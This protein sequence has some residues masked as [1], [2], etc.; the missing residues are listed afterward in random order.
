MCTEPA[1]PSPGRSAVLVAVWPEGIR[2][3]DDRHAPMVSSSAMTHRG[4]MQGSELL[5][6]RL[7][8]WISCQE[9][10]A[11]ANCTPCSAFR[12]FVEHDD[13]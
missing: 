1:Y 6:A 10:A 3:H 9:K 11:L 12:H 2:F 8:A 4:R 7:L 13:A 5:K